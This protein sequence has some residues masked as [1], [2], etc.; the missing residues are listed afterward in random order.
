ML[1]V[2][3]GERAAEFLA[4]HANFRARRAPL[5]LTPLDGGDGFFAAEFHREP[6]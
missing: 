2:E 6:E 4:T 3:N 5:V 1:G